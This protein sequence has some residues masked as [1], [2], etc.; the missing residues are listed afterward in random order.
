M[1][2]PRVVKVLCR[3]C[4]CVHVHV[5]DL[6]NFSSARTPRRQSF[7]PALGGDG[8]NPLDV[9]VCVGVCVGPQQKKRDP[10]KIERRHWS[11]VLVLIYLFMF[12]APKS[13]SLGGNRALREVREWDGMA[14]PVNYTV[15]EASRLVWLVRQRC[16]SNGP[17]AAPSRNG[18]EL[19]QR[20]RCIGFWGR[21]HARPSL[22]AVAE[23]NANGL[24][25]WQAKH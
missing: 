16:A 13:G 6:S 18:G 3:G 8:L 17:K 11:V 15:F 2:T 1:Q 10:G 23:P 7:G 22:P 14:S 19:A 20:A 24:H 4:P 21:L 12:I 9:C 25:T 5:T